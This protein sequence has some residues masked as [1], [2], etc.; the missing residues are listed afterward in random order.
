MLVELLESDGFRLARKTASEMSSPCPWCG[1]NDRFT[2]FLGEGKYWCRQCGKHGDDV[3]YLR[4]FRKMTFPEAA[5]MV[6]KT[7][8]PLTGK[9][10]SSTPRMTA[11]APTEPAKVQHPNGGN[12]RRR[13][14]SEPTAT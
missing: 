14:S 10:R 7:L 4:D 3:Q 12:V 1:G 6:G 5:A 2:V 9:S 11:T 13:A 8:S